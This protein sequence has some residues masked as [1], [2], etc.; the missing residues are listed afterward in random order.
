MGVACHAV[1]TGTR[2]DLAMARYP[3]GRLRCGDEPPGAGDPIGPVMDAFGNILKGGFQ[4]AHPRG[5]LKFLRGQVGQRLQRSAPEV[6]DD[7]LQPSWV[8]PTFRYTIGSDDKE[9]EALHSLDI[10][11]GV[12]ADTL[13]R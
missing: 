3:P 9:V 1:I 4:P 13:L 12:V 7:L 6:G 8:I 2:P 5:R 10:E 11:V